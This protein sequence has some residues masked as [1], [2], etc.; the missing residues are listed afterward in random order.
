MNLFINKDV[1]N[2]LTG[3]SKGTTHELIKVWRNIISL[4]AIAMTKHV[5]VDLPEEDTRH[6]KKQ[7][8]KCIFAKSGDLSSKS[9]L[10]KLSKTYLHLTEEGRIKFLRILAKDFDKNIS[11]LDDKIKIWQSAEND[12]EK[13]KAELQLREAL[14]S[15]R[16]I[17]L[18]KFSTLQNG[19]QFLINLRTDLIPHVTK[20]PYYRKL[21]RDLKDLLLSWFDL[22]LLDLKEITWNS[23]AALLEKLLEY[24][25]VHEI[26]SFRDMKRR[27]R[28][29]RRC[30]AFFHHKIPDEPLIFIEVALTHGLSDNIH[31]L[32]DES[33][34]IVN[35]EHASTVIFYSIS[36]TQKGL[37]GISLGNSLIKRV[38]EKL[39]EE[40][41]NIK[42]FATI[43]PIPRFTEWIENDL[44]EEGKIILT[45]K[46]A[47]L[48]K[49][50]SGEK[51]VKES[52]LQFQNSEWYTNRK[53][54]ES[55]KTPLMK[56]CVYYLLKEKRGKNAYDSVANFHIE[57]GAR[58]ERINWLADISRKGIESSLGM[59][60]NY[61]YE[62]SCIDNNHQNYIT[63]GEIATS[64]EV[65]NILKK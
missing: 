26:Q 11:V 28:P 45:P 19:F 18:K 59:M 32:L 31:K 35:P 58:I 33:A 36:N 34:P 43:S 65:K 54:S 53:I 22:S 55:L 4:T 48:I 6:L 30:Y 8:S 2:L 25:A 17:L 64:K 13:I 23:P 63:Y 38:I 61:S 39:S 60:A 16:V 14:V 12:T 21:D 3:I 40:F 47:M 44:S 49:K 10:A 37:K 56:L 51:S 27:L 9:R 57:N 20:D 52:L 41:K 46:E 42:H 15:P 24:E 5:R 1:K 62:L 50:V 7:I 29:D